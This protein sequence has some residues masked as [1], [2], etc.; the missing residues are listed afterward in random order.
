MRCN[1]YRPQTHLR[2]GYVFTPVCHFVHMLGYTLP[3]QTSPGQTP[4]RTDTPSGRHPLGRH[5]PADGYCCGWLVS[6][7]NAFLFTKMLIRESKY[8]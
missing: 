4:P 5:P 1:I 8:V 3:G 2:K 7:W 6:N